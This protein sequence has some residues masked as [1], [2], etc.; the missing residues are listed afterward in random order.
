MSR[1]SLAK[2]AIGGIGAYLGYKIFFEDNVFEHIRLPMKRNKNYADG[3]YGVTI[4]DIFYDF[5]VFQ[6]EKSR[7]YKVRLKK[8][9]FTSQIELNARNDVFRHISEFAEYYK[10]EKNYVHSDYRSAFNT[11]K[12]TE[13]HEEL[14]QEEIDDI[15]KMYKPLILLEIERIQEHDREAAEKSASECLDNFKRFFEGKN[16]EGNNVQDTK[17]SKANHKEIEL[18]EW[19][20]LH[21]QYENWKAKNE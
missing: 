12:G 18:K 14:H 15:I 11:V 1:I 9:R 8:F 21:N 13:Y 2:W 3:N 19:K 17:E 4:T 20:F 5:E 10:P 16:K 6:D 7:L